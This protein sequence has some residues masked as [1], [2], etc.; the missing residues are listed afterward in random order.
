MSGAARVLGPRQP[1]Q[2]QIM[3]STVALVPAT[4]DDI[5]RLASQD[6]GEKYVLGVMVPKDNSGWKRP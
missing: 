3:S 4:G 5:L 1:N 2:E 6:I